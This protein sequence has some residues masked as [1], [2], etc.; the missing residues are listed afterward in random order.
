M[1]KI[2]NVKNMHLFGA[3]DIWILF[4]AS[5]FDIRIYQF[6]VV[7]YLGNG[8]FFLQNDHPTLYAGFVSC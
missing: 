3:F 7:P 5:C 1:F 8:L 6:K 2:Q 4:S